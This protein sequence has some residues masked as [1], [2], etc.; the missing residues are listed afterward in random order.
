MPVEY[1]A[2]P[3]EGSLPVYV[4][5]RESLAAAGLSAEE[6]AWARNNDFKASR[7]GSCFCLGPAERSPAL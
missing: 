5:P 6:Q 1:V 2:A 3:P 4:V 7:T